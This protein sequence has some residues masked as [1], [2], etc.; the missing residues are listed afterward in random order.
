[1]RNYFYDDLLQK[2]IKKKFPSFNFNDLINGLVESIESSLSLE[3][4]LQAKILPNLDSGDRTESDFYVL[5]GGAA[6]LA[7]LKEIG[8]AKHRVFSES[9][10]TEG[11]R[12]DNLFL[13][14]EGSG[15]KTVIIHEYKKLDK[16]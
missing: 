7:A 4:F 11:G 5:L 14:I 10:V 3:Q 13:P 2:W 1:M 16:T 12:I 8:A 9:Y 15:S 6:A